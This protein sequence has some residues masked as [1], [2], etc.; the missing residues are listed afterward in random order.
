M[1]VILKKNVD[2]LGYK[3]EIVDVKPGYANNF[4][5]PQGYATIATKSTRKAH[6][7]L[8]KQRSHKLVKIQEEAQELAT[9]IESISLK[10]GA[11]VGENGRI[12]GSVNTIQL[13]EAL[14]AEGVE[15]D[16]KSLKIV[17]EPIKEVGSY[18]AIANLY[19]DVAAEF[20]FEVIEE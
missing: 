3:D 15:V 6:T 2:K 17:E 18:T 1:E 16:R 9:K 14:L 4:L 13:S 10:I 5:V 7:E 19:K 20:K 11:K 8:L 12:F